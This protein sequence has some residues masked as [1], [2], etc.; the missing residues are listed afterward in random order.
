[1]NE[2]T[3][4]LKEASWEG[5]LLASV[6]MLG[7]I[8]FEGEAL[9]VLVRHMGYPAKRTMALFIRRQMCIFLQLRHLLQED[10]RQ[11]HILC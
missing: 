7:F 8:Y 1:M 9:R 11:V 6:S 4:S 10:S 3:A 5:I 2:L